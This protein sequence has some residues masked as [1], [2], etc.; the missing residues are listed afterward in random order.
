MLMRC[1]QRYEIQQSIELDQEN[2]MQN[3]SEMDWIMLKLMNAIRKDLVRTSLKFNVS[4]TICPSLG[5]VAFKRVHLI[6][7][8]ATLAH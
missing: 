7:P 8:G 4:N 1:R 5:H 2:Q 3:H 6:S